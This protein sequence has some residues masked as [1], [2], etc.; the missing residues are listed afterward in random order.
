[1][2][3]NEAK[4]AINDSL[5]VDTIFA[6]ATNI[7]K[8]IIRDL[9]FDDIQQ[10]YYLNDRVLR[11]RNESGVL[12]LAY[13]DKRFINVD[14][15]YKR[16]ELEFEIKSDEKTVLEFLDG[17][18]AVKIRDIVEKKRIYFID[19][20]FP[21]L[22]LRLDTYPFTGDFLEI[23]G[24]SF[25]IHEYMKYYSI[26]DHLT[27]TQNCTEIFIKFCEDNRL[28]FENIRTAQNFDNEAKYHGNW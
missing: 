8:V 10:S 13:K 28:E 9:Y 21:D 7:S 19:Y 5:L 11:L 4:I 1:M 20:I 17:M 2:I 16:L 22:K 24:D 6:N 23:E 15:T 26:S 25:Q 18:C 3:E 14:G 12:Y 27:I